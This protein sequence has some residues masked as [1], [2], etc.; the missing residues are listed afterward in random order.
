MGLFFHLTCNKV[1][2]F[3]LAHYTLRDGTIDY[4]FWTQ[5]HKNSNQNKGE[6]LIHG[7]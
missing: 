7:K 2:N 3:C 6:N 1:F 4:L 5:S